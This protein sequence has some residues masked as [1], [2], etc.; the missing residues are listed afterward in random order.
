MLVCMFVFVCVCIYIYIGVRIAWS[1]QRLA[2]DWTVRDR[3]PVGVRFS[4]P[5]QPALEPTQP[6]VEWVTGLFAGVKTAQA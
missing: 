4:T 2:T 5:V 1:V 6:L 3:I